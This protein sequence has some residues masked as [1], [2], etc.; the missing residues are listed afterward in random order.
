MDD[1]GP[2]TLLT[3]ASPYANTRN[4][5]WAL[6]RIDGYVGAVG[7]IGTMRGER[8]AA[9]TD[10]MGAVLSDLSGRGLLYVDP[11]EGP[12]PVA[13][14]WGRHVDIVIDDP[15][16]DSMAGRA[17]I[18]AR[19]AALEQQAKDAGS[20][21]GLVMRPTPVAVARIAVWSNGLPDRGLALAPVSALALPPAGA[22]V[23]LT[24]R[25][26]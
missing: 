26:Q 21:L 11:R 20:A 13:K 3:S 14:A 1:P 12:G 19:L 4:L 5:Y 7:V 24:E 22:A 18:D 9:M 23:T 6:S 8:L 25:E 17:L 16:G 15:V 2:A 10:Q